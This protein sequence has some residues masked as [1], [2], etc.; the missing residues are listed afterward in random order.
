MARRKYPPALSF[1]ALWRQCRKY[2]RKEP[3]DAMYRIAL[4]YAREKFGRHADMA[5]GLAVMLLTWNQAAY[6]Y[7]APHAGG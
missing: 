1:A 5:D 6:R 3:R 7:G 2:W 4:G